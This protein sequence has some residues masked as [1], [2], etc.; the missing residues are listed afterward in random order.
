MA[1]YEYRCP[2]DGDFD[3]KFPV[4]TAASRV[5]C[6]VCG[7]EAVRVFS[8]P[9]LARTPRPLVAA[10]DR[11]ERSAEAPDVVSTIP[12]KPRARRLPVNPAHARL[13]R[14]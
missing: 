7:S 12:A 5:H 14:P 2:R 13:P 11:A 3:V 10:I 4:G 8:A 1:T 6:S 9:L